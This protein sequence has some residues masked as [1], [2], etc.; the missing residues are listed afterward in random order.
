MSERSLK[1]SRRH[2]PKVYAAT[3]DPRIFPDAINCSQP[4]LNFEGI[5][6][7]P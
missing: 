3:M 7:F 5:F 1:S 4:G 6:H 2:D